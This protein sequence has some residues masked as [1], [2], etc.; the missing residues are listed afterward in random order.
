[1]KQTVYILFLL[2][3]FAC[4]TNE[5]E[6]TDNATN[7]PTP[8]DSS[9]RSS[10]SGYTKSDAIWVYRFDSTLNDFKPVKLRA[11]LPD[12]LTAGMICSIL[13]ASWPEVQAKIIRMS[14]DTIYISIPE[15][16][17]LTQQM[18]SSGAQ[19]YMVA[20]TFS[21]T[22]LKGIKYV[23]FDFEEG[24]HAIPGVYNRTSWDMQ[25]Q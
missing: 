2:L 11:V 12:T 13:N 14:K 24:D 1:M 5:D 19:A 20:A 3:L 7:H 4:T 8:G 17:Y 16:N 25:L 6:K 9:D 10:V 18:G 22:E 15:S 23:T 21:F